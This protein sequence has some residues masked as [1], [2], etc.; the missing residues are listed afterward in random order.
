M[1]RKAIFTVNLKGGN[2]ES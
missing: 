2:R 1:T